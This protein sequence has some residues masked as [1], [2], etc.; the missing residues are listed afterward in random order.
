[1]IYIPDKETLIATLSNEFRS[2]RDLHSIIYCTYIFTE[3]PKDLA[4]QLR[5][6]I[7]IMC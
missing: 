5:E 1:M 7:S 3:I 2:I 6:S 4:Y